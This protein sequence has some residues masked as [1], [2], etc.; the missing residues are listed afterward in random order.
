[1]NQ[2]VAVDAAMETAAQEIA[3]NVVPMEPETELERHIRIHRGLIEQQEKRAAE[4]LELG[5]Q[6]AVSVKERRTLL[7]EKYQADLAAIKA[8]ETNFKA[9]TLA[10]INTANRIAKASRAALDSLIASEA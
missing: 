1:M 9:S 6:H 10:T 4:A 3:S 8:A 7:R 5:K 2:H